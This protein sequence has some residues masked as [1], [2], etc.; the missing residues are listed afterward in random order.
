MKN[1]FTVL[2]LI[3]IFFIID[4][5]ISGLYAYFT[6]GFE[7]NEYAKASYLQQQPVEKKSYQDKAYYQGIARRDLFETETNDTPEKKSAV[8]PV[9]PPAPKMQLTALKL[10]LKGTITGTASEPFAVIKKTGEKNEMLYA[11]G[12][13]VDRAVI[14]AIFRE[15]VIL[16]VDGKEETLLMK[17]DTADKK[18]DK[19][20]LGQIASVPAQA[21]ADGF[22]DEVKLKWADINTLNDDLKNLRRQVRVRPHFYKG[23]MDGFRIT[24]IRKNSVFY[25]KLGL[26][27]GDIVAGVNG[28]A[29]KSI[30]DVTTFY[31]GFKQLEGSVATDVDIKR[32][33][34]AGK[35]RY[36]IE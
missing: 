28:E 21:S 32:N 3:L 15:R 34:L 22:V 23:K 20:R 35:I 2:H 10:D 1:V 18:T 11:I 5:F 7:T 24:G 14:K 17:K 27:N 36:S 30:N 33:G 4:F 25:E 13:T 12:D 31:T 16:L 29:M 26:R 19:K 8:K 9:P 6:A